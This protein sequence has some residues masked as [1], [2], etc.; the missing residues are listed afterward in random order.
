MYRY[1]FYDLKMH[2]IW[3]RSSW[4]TLY[5]IFLHLNFEAKK[6]RT[7]ICMKKY[8]M[9]MNY[10]M[11]VHRTY[12]LYSQR[13]QIWFRPEIKCWKKKNSHQWVVHKLR[14][15]VEGGRQSENVKFLPMFI[16]QKMST[17]GGRWSKKSKTCQCS[18]WTTL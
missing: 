12:T 9:D 5:L 13:Y 10:R 18:L 16:R 8:S 3:G 15:R 4:K 7:G 14:L 1:H 17:E 6:V 11:Y 2:F